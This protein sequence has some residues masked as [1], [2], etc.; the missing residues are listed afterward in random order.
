MWVFN[1][2]P[3]RKPA[4]ELEKIR[5]TSGFDTGIDLS[6]LEPENARARTAR[7]DTG[8]VTLAAQR[9]HSDIAP[10]QRPEDLDFRGTA[11]PLT[12][13]DVRAA[14]RVLNCPE[15]VVLAL[16]DAL[17]GNRAGFYGDDRPKLHFHRPLFDHLTG[18]AFPFDRDEAAA[19]RLEGTGEPGAA[20]YAALKDAMACDREAA[21]K[22]ACWGRFALPGL[23]APACGF[24]S[25]DA[26]VRAQMSSEGTQ[27]VALLRLIGLN[28][29]DDD[30]RHGQWAA[31]ARGYLGPDHAQTGLHRKLAEAYA[32]YAGQGMVR[33]TPLE[34][35]RA[36]NAAGAALRDDGVWGPACRQAVRD[37]QRT[38]GLV[39]DGRAGSKTL[40]AL[41]LRTRTTP[42]PMPGSRD[43][44]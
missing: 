20:D 10:L 9:T 40:E 21:L 41:G 24:D 11:S 30:L 33:P 2:N 44:R 31:F 16:G 29:L 34:I 42:Q 14:A 38:N 26:F 5:V 36:L 28:G 8:R 39:M 7:T 32:R 43:F 1:L 4:G 35:Q 15:A 22:A 23:Q 27:L 18:G 37:Y 6:G 25:V 13:G 19:A 17:S 3:K 12:A